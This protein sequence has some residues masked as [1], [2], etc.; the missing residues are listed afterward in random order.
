MSCIYI[1]NKEIIYTSK[2][3]DKTP[4]IF[5]FVGPECRNCLTRGLSLLSRKS[6]IYRFNAIKNNLTHNQLDFLTAV[7]N[8]NHLALGAE[9]FQNDSFPGMG[10]ARYIKI[11]DKDNKAEIAITVLDKYQGKGLGTQLLS[12]LIQ[13]GAKNNIIVFSGYVR[14]ENNAMIGLFDKFN[15]EYKGMEGNLMYME[16]NISECMPVATEILEK[17]RYNFQDALL[18]PDR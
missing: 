13:Y 3:K 2:L 5:Y 6:R 14:P 17:Y 10:V 12:L 8:V 16:L 15:A 11:P 9:K 18:K 4:A 1:K 7:D